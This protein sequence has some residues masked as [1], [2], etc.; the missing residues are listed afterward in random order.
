MSATKTRRRASQTTQREPGRGAA[1]PM[2]PLSRSAHELAKRG[3]PVFPLKP[4]TKERPITKHGFKEATTDPKQIGSWWRRHP[5]ANIGIATG[6]GLTVIDIDSQEAFDHAQELG[7]PD[8]LTARSG[9]D[10]FGQHH[11]F[12]GDL[13]NKLKLHPKIDV[14]GLGACVVAPPSVHPDTGDPYE[15]MTDPDHPLALVPD[16][17]VTR[18]TERKRAT[19]VNGK[20]VE[21]ERNNALHK[22][23]SAMRG[24]GMTREEID[25]ALLVANEMRCDPPLDEDEV[26]ATANSASHHPVGRPIDKDLLAVCRIVKPSALAV[27]IALRKSCGLGN[28][29]KQSYEGLA[30]QA[31][32]GDKTAARAITTLVEAGLVEKKERPFPQSNA[33]R[34]LDIPKQP[35]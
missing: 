6:N 19:T 28:E 11:Y 32:V 12:R 16:W 35:T 33:Y 2:T 7:L 13:P 30:K 25:G 24:I 14:Q 4:R 20:H 3:F 26:R 22:L 8:T 23:A 21:G 1:T 15:W 5:D 9:G 18:K 10:G 31:G 29:C 17:A 34:L 27:Y